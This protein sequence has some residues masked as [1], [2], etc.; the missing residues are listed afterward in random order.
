MHIEKY[1]EKKK[2]GTVSFEFAES[3]RIAVLERRFDEQ[4]GIPRLVPMQETDSREMAGT[5][6]HYQQQADSLLAILA[7]LKALAADIAAKEAEAE[8]LA[9]ENAKK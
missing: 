6:D 1:Q 9:K 8:R 7:D 4:T 3:G 5:I 2:S